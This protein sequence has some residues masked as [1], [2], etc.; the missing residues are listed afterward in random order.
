MPRNRIKPF[1]SLRGIWASSITLPVLNFSPPLLFAAGPLTSSFTPKGLCP[2]W[3][4]VGTIHKTSMKSV[5]QSPGLSKGDEN[6]ATSSCKPFHSS[7]PC[8]FNVWAELLFSLESFFS[9]QV[10]NRGASTA[11]KCHEEILW[12]VWLRL[13]GQQ[14]SSAKE[15]ARRVRKILRTVHVGLVWDWD[16]NN[17][18]DIRIAPLYSFA[19]ALWF[20]SRLQPFWSETVLNAFFCTMHW[21]FQHLSNTN[22]HS[23]EAGV[24][25]ARL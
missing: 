15:N 21:A 25:L 10:E 14:N 2:T 16:S 17:R 6:F 8:C 4:P 19:S 12:V 24:Y 23:T 3:K 1:P 9:M 22:N 5:R 7:K 13:D 18:W 20:P 11:E